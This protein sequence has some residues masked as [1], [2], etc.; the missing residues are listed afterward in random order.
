MIEEDGEAE[1]PEASGDSMP[2][3]DRD[4][5]RAEIAELDQCLLVARGV[6]EDQKSHA[7]LKALDIGFGRMSSI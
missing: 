2:Q 7:L 1:E 5:L 6:R 3:I 4:K